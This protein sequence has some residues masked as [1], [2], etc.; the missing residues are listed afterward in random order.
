MKTLL[1]IVQY[2]LNLGPTVML[3]LALTIIGMAFG[4]GFKKAFR[5]GV[6]IGV[7]FVG[8]NLVIGLLTNN[9]GPAAQA[10]V[11]RFGLHLNII[12]VGW[13]AAAAISWASPVAAIMIPLGLLVNLI[14]LVT[15]TTKTMDIDIWNYWHFT[16]AAASVYVLTGGNFVLA[17][18]GGV[19]YEIAVIKIADWTA[20]MVQDFF[21]LEGVS[22]P[23]GS[24]VSFAPIGIPVGMLVSKIPGIKNLKAD[25]ETI[26]KKFG[27]FGEP[28]MM[29]LV[30]GLILGILAGYDL[31]KI[32]QIGMSMAAVMLLMPRMVKILMEGLIPISESVREFLQKR[33]KNASN[34]NIGLD[35]A[36]V[37][38]H[39]SVIATA[40]ILVPITIFLA[41]ILPG[42]QVLPFGDLA[43]IVFYIAFI[44]G[45]TKGNIIHS[46]ITGTILM[47]LSLYMATDIASFHTMMARQAHFAI[48]KGTSLISSLDMG[49]NLLN[50]LVIKI[51]QWSWGWIALAAIVVVSVIYYFITANKKNNKSAVV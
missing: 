15:R 10:M 27:I 37:V 49:G 34:I 20:P 35:A 51:F 30:L 13:P 31:A 11:H 5:S 36:V 26:Q 29:G 17:A 38:G 43:T 25:P 48:P 21:G 14:M 32:L 23:T 45:S 4:Q 16:A 7:G 33:F 6:T 19:I 42:N 22:L 46:V 3:P 18:L 24:T 50:W 2:I 9:L 1:G 44:V 47:A 28:M 40:L 41:V 12:D 39:P 8:I